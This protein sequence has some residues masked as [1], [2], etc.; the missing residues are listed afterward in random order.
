MAEQGAE[1]PRIP[2]QAPCAPARGAHQRGEITNAATTETFWR[3][4]PR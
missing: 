2:G 3:D 1:Q 4:R